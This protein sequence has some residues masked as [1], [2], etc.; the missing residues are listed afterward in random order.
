MRL[1][2]FFH[3]ELWLCSDAKTFFE[4]RDLLFVLRHAYGHLL[5]YTFLTIV[6]N[7]KGNGST[8]GDTIYT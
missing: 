8:P 2:T 4:H 1:T 7:I 3:T 6:K 5:R